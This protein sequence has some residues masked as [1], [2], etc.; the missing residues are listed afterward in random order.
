MNAGA[1]WL[2]EAS[3]RGAG[4]TIADL[5]FDAVDLAQA[6]AVVERALARGARGYVVT[7]NVDH[8]V[9]YRRNPAYRAACGLSPITLT[10]KPHRVR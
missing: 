4:V 3:R 9:Q 7:P 8:L 2:D 6:V 10:S 5:R 1:G